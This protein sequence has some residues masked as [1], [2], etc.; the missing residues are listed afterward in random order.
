MS[1]RTLNLDLVIIARGGGSKTDL[2]YL[3]NEAIA[4]RI[5]A[6]KYPVWTGIGHETDTSILDHVAN[7]YFKTPTAV[8][9]DIVARFVEM[10]RHLE[11][12]ENRFRSTWS[13]RFDKDRIW[14]DEALT[15]IVQGTRK[16][17]DSTRSYLLGYATT[18]SSKVQGRITNEKSR[19]AVSRNLIATAPI[20]MV[21]RA[22][23]RLNERVGR[24]I[25]GYKRQISE[26][27]KDL[28]N[29]KN[30][31]SPI[32]FVR[33]IQQE[34]ECVCDW[35]NRFLTE[36]QNRNPNTQTTDEPSIWRFQA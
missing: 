15:G 28:L 6:Y 27:Q 12:A 23:E 7:R 29:L 1:W 33:R 3:D 24:F 19:I 35:R 11:E 20:S 31:F 17:L 14:L 10:K 30:G 5:A 16:L 36:I 32:G 22:D 9:E 25:S 34:H 8:A 26:R 13:Y 21:K 2:F 18:L 4:R